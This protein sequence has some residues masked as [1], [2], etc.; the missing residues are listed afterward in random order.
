M[1][2][3]LPHRIRLRKDFSKISTPIELPYLLEI[4]IK[5]YEN[6]LQ[7][8]VKDPKK[9]KVQGLEEVFKQ[10]FPI[11]S[12]NGMLEVRY[13][14]YILETPKYD[15]NECFKKSLTYASPLRLKLEFV[16]KDKTDNQPLEIK[17]EEIYFGEIPL[18]T[19]N[20]SFVINGT[21]RVVVSQLHRSPGVVFSKEKLKTGLQRTTFSSRII[22]YRGSWLDFEFDH[23]DFLFA[24]IDRK[25][26]M[27]ATYI[28]R[29]L[30][31]SEEE[32]LNYFY[33]KQKIWIE[34]N[35]KFYISYFP[36]FLQ[37]L[38]NETVLKD[39]DT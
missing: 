6:F 16:V 3:P 38:K 17:E 13:D 4:Q 33:R 18:M 1:K 11:K 2:M 34:G 36:K 9:R 39:P 25:K 24:R 31:E 19:N 23:R 32:I 35:D 37:G 15:I 5:S 30:A 22:P 20:G 29:A 12:Q 28:L 26:K 21:E 10:I 7:K 27:Y 8:D 14:S